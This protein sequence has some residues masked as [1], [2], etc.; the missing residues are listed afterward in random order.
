MN[1][2]SYVKGSYIGFQ[3]WKNNRKTKKLRNL[4]LKLVRSYIAEGKD[5]EFLKCEENYT[6]IL[7]CELI[8]IDGHVSQNYVRVA[9][10]LYS[11]V[12]K[13]FYGE[14]K[15]FML[16]PIIA[17]R[18]LNDENVN[19]ESYTKHMNGARLKNIDVVS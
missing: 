1:T 3:L 19:L 16:D 7:D 6:S 4:L 15:S 9:A 2:Y 12:W 8:I 13:N 10:Y 11:R 17:I 18:A 5:A 14:G